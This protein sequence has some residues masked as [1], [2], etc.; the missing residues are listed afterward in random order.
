MGGQIRDWP[1]HQQERITTWMNAAHVDVWPEQRP[2]DRESYGAYM[3][4]Y[5][6]RTRARL[7]IPP[8]ERSEEVTQQTHHH[9]SLRRTYDRHSA[10]R[11]DD[12]VRHLPPV[13]RSFIDDR[14]S[15]WAAEGVVRCALEALRPLQLQ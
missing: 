4:W 14:G 9:E 11:L 3:E 7:T 1:L 6:P 12:A 15:I 8:P 10:S 13:V 2:Y 5:V